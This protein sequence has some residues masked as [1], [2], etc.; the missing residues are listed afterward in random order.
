M[1]LITNLLQL[2]AVLSC[3]FLLCPSVLDTSAQLGCLPG[4]VKDVYE[5]NTIMLGS[6]GA[7]AKI[8]SN[9]VERRAF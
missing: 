6:E 5:C 9:S 4:C 1:C 2:H 7:L 3:V 8:D